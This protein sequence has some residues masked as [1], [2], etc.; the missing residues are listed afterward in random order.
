MDEKTGQMLF[1][2][3]I[4]PNRGAWLEYET[5]SSDIFYVRID[6]NRKLPQLGIHSSGDIP[7][8]RGEC[9]DAQAGGCPVSGGTLC[10]RRQMGA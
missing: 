8:V 7:A 5:D 3:T 6:K 9:P 4:I 10:H 2:S 1:S